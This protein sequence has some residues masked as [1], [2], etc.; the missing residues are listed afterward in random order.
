MTVDDDATV[1]S[2][3]SGRDKP[4][5]KDS[6]QDGWS[7]TAARWLVTITATVVSTWALDTVATA[8]GLLVAATPVLDG[9]SRGIVVAFLAATYAVWVI[10]LRVNLTA[11]CR[12]LEETGTST[13]VLSKLLF[14]VARRRSASQRIVRVASMT[15]YVIVEIAKEAPYYVGAFGTALVSDAV[16]AT[17]ALV[18]LGGANLGAAMYEYGLGRLTRTY[19]GGRSPFLGRRRWGLPPATPHASFDIDWRAQEYLDDYYREVEPDEVAT[20]AF[21]VD[22]MRGAERDE[23][24]LLFGVGPTLHHVF[25]TAPVACEIHLADYLPANLETI[26]R[27]LGRA[28]GAHDWRP[29]RRVHARVRGDSRTDCRNGGGPRGADSSQ[30][31]PAPDR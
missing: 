30:G 19:L 24:I 15:G 13:N 31:H 27:W 8:C 22:S 2:F 26:E 3:E 18:F 20:I 7:L 21:F 6:S 9:S 11:N 17:D 14:D 12:L 4:I 25:L 10:G 29:L 16:D 1:L 28:D 5:V 23:P